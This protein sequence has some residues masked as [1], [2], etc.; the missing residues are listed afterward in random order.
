MSVDDRLRGAL[1]AEDPAWD[2]VAQVTL[3][4]VRARRRREVLRRR[5]LV[6]AGLA[7]AVVVAA[8]TLGPDP[9]TRTGQDPATEVPTSD[10]S[11]VPGTTVL[12]GEWLTG[13]IGDTRIR[14][15]LRAAGLGSYVDEIS[16]DLPDRP[17]RIRLTVAGDAVDVDLLSAA[18]P[19][20]FDEE[21]LTLDGER[22]VLR[23]RQAPGRSVH[24]WVLEGSELRLRF[25]STTEGRV[26]GVPGEAW[27]RL[28]YDTAPFRR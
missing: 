27:Q 6:A 26:G 24:R 15:T 9:E 21:T 5:G 13:P 18:G 1:R 25:V 14:R 11:G 17:F 8:T 22:V 20:R 10:P 3:G 2:D 23:P 4:R 7:A 16:A 19:Q 28:T 12:D